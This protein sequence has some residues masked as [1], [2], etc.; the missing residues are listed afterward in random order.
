MFVVLDELL[1]LGEL[2]ADVSI[3][4]SPGVASCVVDP[5]NTNMNKT[6]VSMNMDT[7]EASILV[8]T[9]SLTSVHMES[10]LFSE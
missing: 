3:D 8:G 6:E 2:A 9:I 10:F 5:K 4:K 1:D 7:R